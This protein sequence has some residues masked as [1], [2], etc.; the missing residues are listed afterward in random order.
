[1]KAKG[2]EVNVLLGSGV[3]RIPQVMRELHRQKF[4]GVIALEYE[5]EGG[6]DEDMVQEIAFVRSLA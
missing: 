2:G 1:V 4:T 5:K 3:A 6:I